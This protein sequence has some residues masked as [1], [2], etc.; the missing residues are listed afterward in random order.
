MEDFDESHMVISQ[1]RILICLTLAVDDAVCAEVSF[2][3]H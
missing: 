1:L 3:N 2:E